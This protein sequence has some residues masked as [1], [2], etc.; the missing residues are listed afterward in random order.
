M[1][2]S[3]SHDELECEVSTIGIDDKG[4]MAKGRY[5]TQ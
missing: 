1:Q 4:E 2:I 3:P 5:K